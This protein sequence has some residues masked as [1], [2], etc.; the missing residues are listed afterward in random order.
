MDDE[1]NDETW[2]ASAE[3]LAARMTPELRE[4]LAELG[5]HIDNVAIG[6]RDPDCELLLHGHLGAL[7]FSPQVQV[8]GQAMFDD[9]FAEFTE[10]IIDDEFEARRRRWLGEDSP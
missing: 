7:A 4:A 1:S 3:E 6:V 8:P 9:A 2:P 10:S 5:I